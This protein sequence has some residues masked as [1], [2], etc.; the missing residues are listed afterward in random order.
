MKAANRSFRAVSE[1]VSILILLGVSVIAGYLIYRGFLYQAQR[2]Q[3]SIAL[4]ERAARERI[5]ERFS[6]VAGYIRIINSTTK[7]FV[8][9]I[10]NHGET[11]LKIWK[12]HVPAI[13]EGGHLKRLVYELNRTILSR[14]IGAIR[15]VI[16]DP[17]IG[18]P[19]GVSVKI[20]MY[21][22]SNRVYE[23]SVPV[24]RG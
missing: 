20:E 11:D 5:G 3:Y 19:P 10:Y 22:F 21:T 16:D 17:T 18:Y 4:I 9:V 12:V 14:E 15:I 1:M 24:I 6:L 7:E 23:F 2:Q 8:L 13:L